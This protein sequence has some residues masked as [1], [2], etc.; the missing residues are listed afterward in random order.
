M[1]SQLGKGR[2]GRDPGPCQGPAWGILTGGKFARMV[3]F[4][5]PHLGYEDNY[6]DGPWGAFAEALARAEGAP[7]DGGQRTSDA[8]AR[9]KCGTAPVGAPDASATFATVWGVPLR[10]RF[11]IPAGPLLNARFCAAA[12]AMG[13]DVNV[14]KTV[15]SRAWQAH[16]HPH[17]LAVNVEGDLTLDQA[18][19][20]VQAVA[21]F[22]GVRAITNSF[23]VP[24]AH[25]D[26]WQEDMARAV[27]AAGP[28][29]VL[30]GSFQ[31]SHGVHGPD[32]DAYVE[33]H[34]VTAALVVETGARVLELNL[35]CPNEGTSSLLCTD[36]P[37]V[38]RVLRAVRDRI[39][40]VPL[41]VKMAYMPHD[42]ML[43]EF[44]T[45]TA[46]Y[47]DGYS[48]INTIPA[49]LIAPDGSPALPGAGREVGGVCGDAIAWAAH[50]M[51][52]RLAQLRREGLHTGVI[53]GVGGAG[54]R[55]RYAALRAAGADVVLSATGAMFNPYLARELRP[56]WGA[57]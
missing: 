45:R 38:V 20:G 2:G 22:D 44:V 23:G 32:E 51:G 19:R 28:G 34:A 57:A 9:G 49:R 17:V 27:R 50:D 16:P 4:Y 21:S 13:F 14:Y 8:D 7:S 26:V 43:R 37:L 1:W 5:D 3:P 11:G 39:G 47:V 6:R 33:D 36:V 15:R 30:V 18:A 53:V 25:P 56:A 40:D 42:A 41:V 48:A 10:S 35:S 29:Q 31:G 54:S 12:F 55:E 24:S 46:P 52:T